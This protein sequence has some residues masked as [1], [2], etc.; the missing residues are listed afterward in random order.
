MRLEKSGKLPAASHVDHYSIRLFD[1][2][3]FLTKKQRN[4]PL[5]RDLYRET[6]LSMFHGTVGVELPSEV[7]QKGISSNLFKGL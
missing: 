2:D 7:D 3:A 6:D 4:F 1:T 5:F